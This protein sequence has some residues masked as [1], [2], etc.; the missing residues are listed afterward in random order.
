MKF[1][2]TPQ[3]R[4]KGKRT[5]FL[6]EEGFGDIFFLGMGLGTNGIRGFGVLYRKLR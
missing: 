1:T 2:P 6:M 3:L 5:I 4:E